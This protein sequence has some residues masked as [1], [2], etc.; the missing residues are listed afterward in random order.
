MFH[1]VPCEIL[2]ELPCVGEHS[3][4][5]NA[6]DACVSNQD[7]FYVIPDIFFLDDAVCDEVVNGIFDLADLN[8]CVYKQSHVRDTYSCDLDY[9]L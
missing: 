5:K 3:R 2:K 9:V 8:D 6:H 7:G 1:D 4:G